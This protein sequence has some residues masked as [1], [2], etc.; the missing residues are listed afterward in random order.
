M[1]GI[2]KACGA[3][4]GF[5]TDDAG[6]ERMFYKKDVR[7]SPQVWLEPGDCVVFDPCE[8]PKG[9]AALRVRLVARCPRR[10]D[11]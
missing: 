8:R 5:L 7:P 10:F 4:F 3:G 2:V 1:T 9:P 11:P 6:V